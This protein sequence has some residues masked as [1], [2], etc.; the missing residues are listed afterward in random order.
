[1]NTE[2]PVDIDQVLD[3]ILEFEAWFERKP[4][5]ITRADYAKRK[6]LSITQSGAHLNKLV[7]MGKLKTHEVYDPAVKRKVRIWRII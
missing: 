4:G 7:E 1:M 3:E 2:Q 6:G 5:D